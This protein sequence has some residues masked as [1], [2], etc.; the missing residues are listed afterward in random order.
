MAGMFP[1]TGSGAQTVI[2]SSK[3][4]LFMDVHSSVPHKI[5][6]VLGV[7]LAQK[8]KMMD[9]SNSHPYIIMKYFSDPSL[10]KVPVHAATRP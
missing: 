2:I 9:F 3:R 4:Q 5:L 6:A 7:V 10:K 1:V 8:T